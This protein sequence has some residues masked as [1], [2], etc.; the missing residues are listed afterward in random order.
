ME[1]LRQSLSR[2]PLS[3]EILNLKSV[4]EPNEGLQETSSEKPS[5]SLRGETEERDYHKVCRGNPSR[6]FRG[7]T[8]ER[9]GYLKLCR[10][11]PSRDG[12]EKGL[13]QANVVVGIRIDPFRCRR[14]RGYLTCLGGSLAVTRDPDPKERS[15]SRGRPKSARRLP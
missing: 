13:P 10:R 5:P 7:E 14:G 11:N 9:K 1:R 2:Q 6:S 4:Q 8:K 12:K 3:V 15:R